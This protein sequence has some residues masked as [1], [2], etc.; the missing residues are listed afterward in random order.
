[1]HL[2]DER[3]N[4]AAQHDGEPAANALR[5]SRW[6]AGEYVEDVHPLALPAN[7][8]AGIYRLRVGMYAWPDGARLP[9]ATGAD[10]FDLPQ[11]LTVTGR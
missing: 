9:L 6:A 4:V 10:A 5:T 7:L 1:M 2:L 11:P 3:G 8:P